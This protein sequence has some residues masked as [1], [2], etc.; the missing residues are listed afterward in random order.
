MN[1]A[2]L[3]HTTCPNCLIAICGI[4]IGVEDIPANITADCP[5]CGFPLHIDVL[6]ELL[7]NELNIKLDNEYNI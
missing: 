6:E 5:M 1:R 4:F 2:V 3:E 7:D